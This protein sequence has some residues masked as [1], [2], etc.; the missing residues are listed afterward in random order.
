[1]VTISSDGSTV[2]TSDDFTRLQNVL[3][4]ITFVN[5]PTQSSATQSSY[6]A[7]PSAVSSD[8]LCS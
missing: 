3:S 5:E 6:P 7:C 1:M 8:F 2:T 4:N